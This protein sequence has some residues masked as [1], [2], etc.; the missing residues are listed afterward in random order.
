MNKEEAVKLAESKFWED[1]SLFERAKFQLFEDRLCMP[2][3]I[4]HE[5]LEYA[6]GR[7]VWTH[8]LGFREN[9]INEFLGDKPAPSMEEIINLIPKGKRIIMCVK[10]E[11]RNAT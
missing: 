1:M 2:F 3:E 5:A 4:F 6:L 7:S 11:S 10:E 8:E 9:I